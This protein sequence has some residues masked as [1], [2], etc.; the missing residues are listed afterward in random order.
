M[1]CRFTGCVEIF[2]RQNKNSHEKNCPH[3]EKN[4]Q[5]CEKAFKV[6]L[7]NVSRTFCER[8]FWT[9]LNI[10]FSYKFCL[11]I[12]RVHQ[13]LHNFELSMRECMSSPTTIHNYRKF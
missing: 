5:Y 8:Y 10:Q 1:K 13:F 2:E 7:E 6:S 12:A 11:S 3:K 4:C 9:I